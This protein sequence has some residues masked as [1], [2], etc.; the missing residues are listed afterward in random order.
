KIQRA[1]LDGNNVEDL[2]TGLP[3]PNGIA[4]DTNSGKMY[5]T[6]G[7]M[8]KIQRA[9]L[10]GNNV[11]DLVTGLANPLGIALDTGIGKMYWVVQGTAKIQRADLDGNNVEDL[12]TGLN[13]PYDIA[14]DLSRPDYGSAP[15]APG[16]TIG[17]GSSPLGVAVNQTFDVQ[18]TGDAGLTVDK[19]ATAIT[20]DHASDFS[21][22]SPDF[23]FTITDGGADQTVTLACTPSAE[24]ERTA[25][26]NLISNDSANAAVT[27]TLTCTGTAVPAAGYASTPAPSDT[28]NFG[29]S[30]VGVAVNQT[31]DVQETG[32][33]V[34][35]V[36]KAATAIT[37]AH[38]A[39]FSIVSPVFP[40]TIADGDPDQTVTVAC[41]PSA[42]G[43]RT[44]TLN[45]TSNDPTNA[46]VT[47]T[48]TCTGTATT[49]T[50]PATA[51]APT[52]TSV[53]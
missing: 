8:K 21:I 45:L 20:G 49:T 13:M 17:F 50:I 35:T 40:F 37:G 24:G 47:Y 18:E 51:T 27:Y 44:A 19:A 23:P 29:S 6:E 28:I 39:D 25:T 34:L 16:G 41:T 42:E 46:A 9:D 43:V 26:L 31:F 22:V 3:L 15:I 1:D 2:V 14:L 36:D 7:G 32:N 30:T 53:M 48:L 38:A 10:D 11:E 5:W 4:L 52:V 12:V 33:A